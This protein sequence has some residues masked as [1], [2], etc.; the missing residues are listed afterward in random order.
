ML[1]GCRPHPSIEPRNSSMELQTHGA[2]KYPTSTLLKSSASLGWTSL[3]AELRSHAV[4]ETPV[5]VPRHLELTLA[6][7]G[8][9]AGLVRRTGA[10]QCQQTRAATGTIWMTPVTVGDNEITITA[11]LP[12]TLH[13]YVPTA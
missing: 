12:Q 10:G 9:R 7:L 5:V 13:L 4:S 8:N 2:R 6:V 1:S 11:P 3:G